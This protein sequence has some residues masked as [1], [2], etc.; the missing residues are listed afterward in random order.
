MSFISNQIN[1]LLII[2]IINNH[3]VH[4]Y[5][6]VDVISSLVHPAL[7]I[8]SSRMPMSSLISGIFQLAS[9]GEENRHIFSISMPGSGRS[10]SDSHS[11]L[12]FL[13][14]DPV[15]LL[16]SVLITSN[17]DRTDSFHE[18]RCFFVKVLNDSRKVLFRYFILLNGSIK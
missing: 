9:G 11:S 3:V 18:V 13:A 5:S 6:N 4:R 16:Q 14:F 8:S 12:I 2:Y 1:D 7:S 15:V 17:T 10:L